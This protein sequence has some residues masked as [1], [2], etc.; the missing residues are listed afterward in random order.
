MKKTK[1]IALIGVY[2][3]LLIGGQVALSAISGVEVVSVLLASFALHYGIKRG[4]LV[5]TAF[6][7]LRCLVFGFFPNVIILYLIYYNLFATAFGAL[8][9]R[10]KREMNPK[11]HV[12][13]V[14]VGVAFTILFTLLD[15]VITPLYYGL[16]Y[17]TAFGYAYTSL[18]AVLP[19]VLCAILT[20]SLFIRPLAK[21][22]KITDR[23]S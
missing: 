15:N 16:D 13:I 2:T 6:S 8:G 12:F 5:A 3:A 14:A 10:Y 17:K 23:I 1:E 20:F 22:L 7:L 21:I 4:M 19:Q 11:R 18:Y 9:K